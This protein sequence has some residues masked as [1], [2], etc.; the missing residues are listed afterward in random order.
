MAVSDM[1]LLYEGSQ[2]YSKQHF[3]GI[4][5]HTP[6]QRHSLVGL[7]W[8]Q[9]GQGCASCVQ[10]H[11]KHDDTFAAVIQIKKVYGVI[12]SYVYFIVI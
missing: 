9:L 11:V 10:C 2:I 1:K 8:W 6:L 3:A 12:N 7:P 4:A 5:V